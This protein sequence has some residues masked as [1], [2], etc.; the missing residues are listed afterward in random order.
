LAY[1][2][3]AGYRPASFVDLYEKSTPGKTRPGT[4]SKV[5]FKHP[6]THARIPF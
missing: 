5:F 4:L 3:K 2:E 6:M 1:V